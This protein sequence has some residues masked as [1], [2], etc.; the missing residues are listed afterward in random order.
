MKHLFL[1]SFLITLSS[2]LAHNNSSIVTEVPT[3]VKDSF[4]LKFPGIKAKWEK[5]ESNYEANFKQNGKEMSATFDVQGKLI[6]TEIAI[7]ESELPENI[8]EY[9]KNNLK[10]KIQERSKIIKESGII[11]YEVEIKGKDYVFD[12]TGKLVA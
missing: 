9:I 2:V 7:T 8:K 5:E 10:G 4:S 1:F 3:Q 12:A 6:E 11:Q